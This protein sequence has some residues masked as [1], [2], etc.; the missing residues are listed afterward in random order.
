MAYKLWHAATTKA[1]KG[2][3]SRVELMLQNRTTLY[4]N[5]NV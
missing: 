2:E 3:Q 1:V 4:V 5:M